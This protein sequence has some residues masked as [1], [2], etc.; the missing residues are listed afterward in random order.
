MRILLIFVSLLAIFTSCEI[1]TE[2]ASST[3]II[4]NDSQAKVEVKYY[5]NDDG[6]KDSLHL[7]SREIARFNNYAD[8]DF[9]AP[10]PEEVNLFYDSLKIIYNDT[11]IRYM[12]DIPKERNILKEESWKKVEADDNVTE[13][14][15]RFTDSDVVDALVNHK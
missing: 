2:N 1:E 4:V 3:F 12:K 8:D 13:Y 5:L 7:Q 10:T 6:K 15:Y 9:D 14:T 11:L